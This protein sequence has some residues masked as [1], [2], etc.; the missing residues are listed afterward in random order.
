MSR[1]ITVEITRSIVPPK[2]MHFGIH[3][4]PAWVD[5]GDP[6]MQKQLPSAAMLQDNPT[7]PAY[8]GAVIPVYNP[9]WDHIAATNDIDGEAYAHSIGSLWINKRPEDSPDGIARAECVSSGGNYFG[10]YPQYSTNAHV[11]IE[12]FSNTADLDDLNPKVYNW[13]NMPWMDWECAS[14]TKEN[15]SGLVW[16]DVNCFIPRI[17]REGAVQWLLKSNV[18]LF[19]EG[20]SYRFRNGVEIWDDDQPLLT[21]ENGRRVL[22][23]PLWQIPSD[24]PNVVPPVRPREH[25]IS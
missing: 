25:Y 1:V 24:F 14:F 11:R 5:T 15:H 21:F 6:G 19:P 3:H 8:K 2:G 12:G 13:F 22:H 20:Y 9:V 7:F 18:W 4:H 17:H 16:G 23:N 10:Y